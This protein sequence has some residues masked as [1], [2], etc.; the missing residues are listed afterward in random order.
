M[1]T[2]SID[3]VQQLSDWL[4]ATDIARLEL[5]GPGETVCLRREGSRIVA[6]HDEPALEHSAAPGMSASA[7]SVGVFLHRHPLHL[8]DHAALAEAGGTVRCG[9]TVGLL[10]IG[11]LLLP[12]TS[13][14]DGV[15][16][17]TLVE[18]GTTVGYGERLMALQPLPTDS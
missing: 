16:S 10:Q 6:V 2:S 15:V 3:R 11:A 13:P 8:A 17:G 4:R 12:V 1:T 7:Q 9:Q 18:H 14:C 5:R